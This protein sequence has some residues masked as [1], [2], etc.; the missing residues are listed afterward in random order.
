MQW[1]MPKMSNAAS[2]HDIA[3]A[4]LDALV[5]RRRLDA[6]R[7]VLARVL[8]SYPQSVELLQYAAWVEWLDDHL[9]EAHAHV[10][11]VLALDPESYAARY[12]LVQ[13]LVEQAS[14]TEAE[15]VVLDLITRYPRSS[16]LYALYARVM[17]L[18]F[19][20]DKADA[21]AGEALRL[22][23]SNE[24]ALNVHVLAGFIAHPP[25]QQRERLQK[26][27]RDYPDQLSTI[28]RLIQSLIAQGKRRQ[29]Y[30][31]AR[32]LVKLYPADTNVVAL[33][34]SLRRNTHW[35]LLPLWPMQ[36]WGWG[37]SIGLWL[38]AVM[39]FRSQVLSQT[40]LA[41]HEGTLATIF[42][43]YVVYSWV[44]PPLLGRLQR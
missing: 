20:V 25:D 21:L 4:E 39:L 32:D 37:G 24:N 11:N 9:D 36:K 40:P 6:A 27:L 12:L 5:E 13:I 1:R 19:N 23:P 28:I 22:D 35:S 14:Y 17:L 18:T 34:A 33:A 43:V 16:D 42:L 10:K 3:V 2:E 15:Q 41:G 29:A 38:L 30:A 7:K 31:L 26:L 44:W 8:P